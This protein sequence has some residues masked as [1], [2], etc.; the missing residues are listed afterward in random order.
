MDSVPLRTAELDISC[1]DDGSGTA[2]RALRIVEDFP[3]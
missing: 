3:T 2:L 1:L